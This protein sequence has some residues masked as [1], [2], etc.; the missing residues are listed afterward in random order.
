MRLVWGG[1]VGRRARVRRCFFFFRRP[2]EKKRVPLISSSSLSQR[3]VR[4]AQ[5]GP[6]VTTR[7]SKRPK[8]TP[9][10]GAERS[11][12][13]LFK[14]LC[15]DFADTPTAATEER[16]PTLPPADTTYYATPIQLF[17]YS[18][19]GM[20][21]LAGPGITFTRAMLKFTETPDKGL[22]ADLTGLKLT[23]VAHDGTETRG[24]YCAFAGESGGMLMKAAQAKPF[25]EKIGFRGTD[26]IGLIAGFADNK[27]INPKHGDYADIRLR[28]ALSPWTFVFKKVDEKKCFGAYVPLYYKDDEEKVDAWLKERAV[29]FAWLNALLD[30]KPEWLLADAQ[31]TLLA[32]ANICKCTNL[33]VF[34]SIV[35]DFL[36]RGMTVR[37]VAYNPNT[38]RVMELTTVV[39]REQL[40]TIVFR[41]DEAAPYASI[42]EWLELC[43]IH[44]DSQMQI[45]RIDT[46]EDGPTHATLALVK[47]KKAELK[48]CD[49]EGWVGTFK[50][51]E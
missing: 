18:D 17:D 31:P 4:L 26:D 13:A 45:V 37:L 38:G 24:I 50:K 10:K 46:P 44:S 8:G 2:R 1:G 25:F 34:W 6:N 19:L 33:R 36:R 41:P 21:V 48:E 11:Y 3:D 42:L 40:K 49:M 30:A 32:I 29:D 15:D 20:F 27:S 16:P 23:L 7:A 22:D 12:A 47:V 43:D 39:G 28:V 51:E 9:V 14:K 35:M 5:S